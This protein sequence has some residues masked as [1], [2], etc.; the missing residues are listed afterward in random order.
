MAFRKIHWAGKFDGKEERLPQREHPEG[1][2][3]FKEAD[4]KSLAIAANVMA[5]VLLAFLLVTLK[6]RAG[7]FFLSRIGAILTLVFILPHEFL[8]AIAM[9]GDS[10]FYTNLKQGMLFVVSKEDM[11]KARCIIML[12]LPNIIFG[13]I[14]YILFMIFP[15]QEWLGMLGTFSIV[16]GTGDYY[17]VFLV[18]AQVPAGATVYHSGLHY[19]WYVKH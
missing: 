12:L 13:F 17:N 6:L 10:F 5:F 11:S 19:Y 16:L 9:N 14:P 18:A 8:H 7:H 4:M 2:V 1:S 15:Q 3:Q